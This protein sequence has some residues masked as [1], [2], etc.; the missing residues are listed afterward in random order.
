MTD[1]SKNIVVLKYGG[2]SVEDT[3]K[4]IS[5]AKKIV[6][7]KKTDQHV[8]VVVS[9]MGRT[10]DS[11]YNQALS[12][13]ENPCKRE[14]DA[15]LTTGEQQSV[16][17]LCIALKELGFDAVSLTGQQAGIRTKG[18]HTKGKIVEIDD[19]KIIGYLLEGKI[20]VVAGFQGI[21]ELG[22][23]TTLG[24]GGS[25]TTAVALAV[26]L[27]CPCEIYTDVDGV[28]TMDPRIYP[29]AKKLT[30]ISYDKML[31]MASLGAKVLD[32]RAIALGR[33]Y[34][35][36]IY[37]AH[38]S[39]DTCGTFIRGNR[40]MEDYEVSGLVIDNNLLNVIIGNIP[41]T[42]DNI[43]KIFQ[44]L[45]KNNIEVSMVNSLSTNYTSISFMCSN[46]DYLII[47]DIKKQFDT[48]LNTSILVVAD[49][50]A[51]VSLVGEGK[52]NQ[53]KT[54]AR[55]VTILNKSN[56][57]YRNLYT[58][59]TY[60]SYICNEESNLGIIKTLAEEFNL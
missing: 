33:K 31:E 13:S 32:K 50:V 14:L 22:D 2:T 37:I 34:N 11:L 58:C 57:R 7:R 15:L 54:I 4:I 45:E 55:L 6:H 16:A 46:E 38:S 60:V 35:I 5:V 21:N 9:A 20:V 17:L 44:L 51:R 1:Y 10:T 47:N 42:L 24:R 36:P 26:K 43:L 3:D 23:I 48:E 8:V 19:K 53:V 27:N 49:K 18:N 29:K 30:E 40:S 28:Y 52:I 12:I 39:K 56:L 25:D 41:N 59:E